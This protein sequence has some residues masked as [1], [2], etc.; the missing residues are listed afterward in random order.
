MP[1]TT[2]SVRQSSVED[3]A[4][5][6]TR[7]SR[8]LRGTSDDSASPL[9]SLSPPKRK[10]NASSKA[11]KVPSKLYITRQNTSKQSQQ[12]A[13][14]TTAPLGMPSPDEHLTLET[15]HKYHSA[16]EIAIDESVRES[17]IKALEV[18][19]NQNPTLVA[20]M[21]LEQRSQIINQTRRAD[22]NERVA[23]IESQRATD[24]TEKLKVA[25]TE[26]GQVSDWVFGSHPPASEKSSSTLDSLFKS[27]PPASEKSPR[28]R[29]APTEEGD[30]NEERP[31]RRQRRTS[32]ERP[33][34]RQRLST[35]AA[36]QSPRESLQES[37]QEAAHESAQEAAEESDDASSEESAEVSP[38]VSPQMPNGRATTLTSH[39]D[40]AAQ[41][42]ATAAL[43]ALNEKSSHRYSDDSS[44]DEEDTPTRSE[45]GFKRYMRERNRQ[46]ELERQKEEWLGAAFT[47]PDLPVSN[48]QVLT[49]SLSKAHNSHLVLNSFLLR[50]FELSTRITSSSLPTMMAT[51]HR[52][53]T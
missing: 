34:P 52:P 41:F 20:R 45:S 46:K 3:G 8:R 9:R 17:I 37:A 7:T 21:L 49:R 26:L 6:P 42:P 18:L 51:K 39:S 27:P 38:Q 31:S 13:D 15:L 29:P 23:E 47:R 33:S 43:A 50:L 32:Q 28:K 16:F 11:P 2:R 40:I 1:K 25:Q 36:T 10:R 12:Q 24:A 53:M 14:A 19:A 22:A 5:A 48:S 35:E 30:E 4:A 44:D